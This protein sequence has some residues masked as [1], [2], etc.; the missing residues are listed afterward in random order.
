MKNNIDL[1]ELWSKQTVPAANQSELFNK[2][3]RFRRRRLMRTISLNII[4]LITILF[5]VFVWLYYKPLLISTK[6]GIVLTILSMSMVLLFNRQ[7]LPLYKR[8]NENQSNLNYLNNLLAVRR[9]EHFMQTKLMIV[10]FLL[11]STGI[12]LY[13]YEYII[14]KSLVYVIVA[15][16]LFFVWAG[17]NWFYLRTKIIGKNKKR[18]DNLIKHVEKINMS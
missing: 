14:N 15:Y 5:V 1:K 4:L 9:K 10:Y 11:L 8:L 3:K 7:L 2:I 18:I 13:M 17:F 16:L 12:C 6:A